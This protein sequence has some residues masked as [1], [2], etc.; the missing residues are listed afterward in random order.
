MAGPLCGRAARRSGRRRDQGRAARGRRV[1]ARDARR[2]RA[3]ALLRAAEPRQAVGRARPEDATRAAT[4]CRRCRRRRTSSLHN[5][6]PAR[7]EPFGLGWEE[8]HARLAAARRSAS[9]RRS[10]T[11]ARWRAYRRTTSSRRRARVCSRR[12]RRR[13][14][15]CRCAPVGSRWPTSRPGFLLSTAVLA[16]LVRARETGVGERVDVSLLAAAHGGAGAGSRLARRGAPRA[17]RAGDARR[18]DARAAEIAAASTMNP[19]YRCFEAADGF[20]AVACLN[21]GQRRALLALL[22]ARRRDGR[23]AG[24]DPGRCG[25]CSRASGG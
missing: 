17:G 14:T 25:P 3:R 8:L 4:R 11:R 22:R 13:A 6:P 23:R 12:M 5:A 24:P 19:Y 20:V 15:T 16:A 7:A 9:S 10:G 1:P 2:A 18:P 21:V